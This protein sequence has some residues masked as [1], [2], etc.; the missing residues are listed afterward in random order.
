[1]KPDHTTPVFEA[2]RTH[3]RD[4]YLSALLCPRQ[5]RDDLVALAAVLGDIE[6]IPAIVTEPM[7]GEMRVQWWLDWLDTLANDKAHLTGNPLADALAEVIARR[8]LPIAPLQEVCEARI[9]DL[10]ADP[11][12]DIDAARRYVD[13]TEVG[14]ARLSALIC[15]VS[16]P[17]ST[18][19]N[20]DLAISLA[21]RA[22]GNLKLLQKLPFFTERGRW[23]L[24]PYPRTEVEDPARLLTRDSDGDR[25]RQQA[26]GR[27]ISVIEKMLTALPVRLRSLGSDERKLLLRALRPAALVPD[28]LAQ[29]KR[30]ECWRLGAVPDITQLK[31]VWSLY[32]ATKRLN[33]SG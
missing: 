7:L 33:L 3:N 1:M 12:A 22:I 31:R 29:L 18:D 24:P 25:R 11:F 27:H 2:A 21:G 5:D 30:H 23:P 8:D 19:N 32:R 13:A 16:E 20:A 26:V 9:T 10:Y 28:Y 4:R 15:G 17:P 6:R 14:P